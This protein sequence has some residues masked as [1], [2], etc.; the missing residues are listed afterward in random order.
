MP[1]ELSNLNSSPAV[2]VNDFRKTKSYKMKANETSV[3]RFSKSSQLQGNK[4][5]KNNQN[6]SILY[7]YL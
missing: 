3:R 4:N 2:A 6:R 5:Y 1:L 7:K